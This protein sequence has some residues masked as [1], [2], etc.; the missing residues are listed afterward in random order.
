[1]I[2][3][4]PYRSRLF[5]KANLVMFQMHLMSANNV[6]MNIKHA[7]MINC[8]IATSSIATHTFPG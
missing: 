5:K 4:E 1:M 6:N 2:S 3:F 8:D 7:A